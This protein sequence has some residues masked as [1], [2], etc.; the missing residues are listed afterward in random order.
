MVHYLVL[1]IVAA[2]LLWTTTSSAQS[3]PGAPVQIEEWSHERVSSLGRRI[4]LHDRAAWLATDA[5]RANVTAED[6]A[7]VRGWIVVED[8]AGLLV[9]FAR[10]ADGAILPGWDVSV[11][12]SAGPVSPA[13]A[14]STFSS[15]ELAQF[16]AR[17]TAGRGLGALRCSRT[18]N[19]VVF[20]D[21]DGDGW[22]VWL[23]AA[24]TEPGLIPVGG[25]YRFTISSDGSTIVRRDQLSNSCL[26]MRDDRRGPNGERAGLVVNQIVS[27]GPVETHV[28][29]SLLNQTPIYVAADGKL[30]AVEGDRIRF[31]Q[32]IED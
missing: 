22:L 24:T 21:P 31:V 7:Q 26:N 19:S 15:S 6:I 18:M 16:A 27:N 14:G 1:P 3:S 23:L 2:A 11:G 32:T 4:F 29:L 30:F 10:E 28:F 25:H 17:N 20:E 13:P 9:R 12:E 8:P 5:L